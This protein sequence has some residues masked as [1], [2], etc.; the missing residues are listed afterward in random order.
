MDFPTLSTG[1]VLQYP[2]VKVRRFRN[3][4][5]RFV[6][7]SEQRFRQC[8]GVVHAWMVRLEKLTGDELVRVAEFLKAQGGRSRTFSFTDPFDGVTYEG[9]HLGEDDSQWS[10]AEQEQGLA[11]VWIHKTGG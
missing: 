9:C 6:D 7:G 11:V 3:V 1:A 8:G 2:T 5:V 4:A 10:L